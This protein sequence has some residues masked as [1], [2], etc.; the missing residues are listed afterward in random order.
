[1]DPLEEVPDTTSP[2]NHSSSERVAPPPE[3]AGAQDP[4][5]LPADIKA[6]GGPP[7]AKSEETATPDQSR[8]HPIPQIDGT[9]SCSYPSLPQADFIEGHRKPGWTE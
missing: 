4:C 3:A 9:S 2:P 8:R 7:G 5:P 6:Q 1:M